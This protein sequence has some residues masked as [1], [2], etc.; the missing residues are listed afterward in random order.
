VHPEEVAMQPS[1]RRLAIRAKLHDIDIVAHMPIRDICLLI[2]ADNATG[3]LLN[4]ISGK[5]LHTNT[6]LPQQTQS[7]K[8]NK[9]S[10]ICLYYT[11]SNG[12]SQFGILHKCSF[13]EINIEGFVKCS[14]IVKDAHATLSMDVIFEL[15]E[16]IVIPM[17]K[18]DS[19]AT[20]KMSKIIRAQSEVYPTT[21]NRKEK[22]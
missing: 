6:P 16:S 20:V 2:L 14:V 3:Y 9:R 13:I 15:L 5:I 22:K 19:E 4:V 21:P 1:K 12:E 8:T 7:Q 11:W 10:I 17:L 18:T